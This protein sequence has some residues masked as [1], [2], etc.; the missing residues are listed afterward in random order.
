MLIDK[1]R[2]IVNVGNQLLLCFNIK[3][4][5]MQNSVG[6]HKVYA[7]LIALLLVPFTIL[8]LT[9]IVFA[10][11][12]DLFSVDNNRN[13]LIAG[14]GIIDGLLDDISS[15]FIKAT[16][17][18]A[19]YYG[20]KFHNRKTA[21]GERYNMYSMT[22]AHRKLPFGT[23]VRVKN[24]K[25]NAVSLVRIN[26]RGPFI[27]KRIIDLSYE[28]AREIGSLGTPKVQIEYMAKPDD[29]DS[30]L[31]ADKYFGYCYDKSFV[32][33]GSRYINFSDST[34]NFD[35]ALEMLQI[36]NAESIGNDFYL[37]TK[38]DAIDK[39]AKS[40]KEKLDFQIFYYIGTLK[41]LEL[42]KTKDVAGIQ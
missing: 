39:L 38:S 9:F 10:K 1:K 40:K 11:E 23:I 5:L 27:G 8:S 29:K 21:S 12:P 34:E 35:V 6:R 2:Q 18:I 16:E 36:A 31:I 24:L 14:D 28:S 22:A 17:G 20:G 42:P 4:F 15:K 25:N 33:V 19:S 30:A 37:F 41:K 13:S 7:R 26:D 3:G 32:C